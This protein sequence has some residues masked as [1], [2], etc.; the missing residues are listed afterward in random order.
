MAHIRLIAYLLVA[1]CACAAAAVSDGDQDA[2]DTKPAAEAIP[3]LT[4]RLMDALPGDVTIWQ[5]YLSDRVIYVSETGEVANKK[6]LLEAF[7]PFPQGIAG[8]IAVRN[9]RVTEFGNTAVSVFDAHERQTVYD[10]QIEVNYRSTHTW[11]RENGRWRLIAA[12]NVVLAKDPP[13][14]PIDTRRLADYAGTYELSG[15]RQYL[16]EQ[17]GNTLVG[18]RANSELTLLVPIGD[19][20]FVEAGS[21]LGILRIFVRGQTG[22]VER[23][24]Q[25][26]KFAD[27]DWVRVPSPR[28]VATPKK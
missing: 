25:R 11:Q 1:A 14:L 8:S 7:T 20:V 4:Q 21:N 26:R 28:S 3:A 5:R 19:N 17:R 24:V 22:A 18:G 10:Q 9:V 2:P 27:L 23:M 13:A 16:V 15:K 12:Q 6:E